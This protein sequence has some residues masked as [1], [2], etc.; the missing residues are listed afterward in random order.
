NSPQ[1][2]STALF[3]AHANPFVL[4]GNPGDVPSTSCNP[5]NDMDEE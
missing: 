3:D 1:T 5:G 4:F 2:Y